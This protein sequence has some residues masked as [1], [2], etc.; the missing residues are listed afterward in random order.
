MEVLG[1]LRPH[2]LIFTVST[3]VGGKKSKKIFLFAQKIYKPWLQIF[4]A[5]MFLCIYNLK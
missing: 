3:I 4:V 1:R 2:F 5:Q